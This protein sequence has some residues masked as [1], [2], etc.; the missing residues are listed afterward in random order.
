MGKTVRCGVIGAGAIGLIHLEGFK[1]H[2]DVELVGVAEVN[3]QRRQEAAEKFKLPKAVE[4]YTELLKDPSIDV[5]SIGL[6]NYLH[7]DVAVAAIKAGKHVMLDKPMATSAAEGQKIIDAWKEKKVVFMIGQNFRFNRETQMVKEYVKNGELGDIY[8]ARAHW[9]RRSGIPRI[10]SWFTQKKY[11]GGGCCYDIGVHFLDA[12]LHLMGTFVAE[13]VTGIVQ[14]KFG[15]RGLGDGT[16]G[17]GEIDASKPFDVEDLAVA[18]IKLKGGKS[19][20]L[21]ISWAIQADGGKDN[22]IDLY[23]TEG[24]ANLFPA[25]IYKVKGTNY[26]TITPDFK[27][28]PISEDRMVHFIDCVQGK[29]DPIVKPEESLKVQKILD[30]IYESSKTGRE[31]RLS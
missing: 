28:L 20:L 13:C 29:C 27:T 1:K 21:E 7:S 26:E 10:G 12:T 24:G 30:G 18:M 3:A 5:V 22:G 17:K 23:G 4:D 2:P 31:V 15:P 16:W 25:K 6:P 19:V 14:A 8:H 9:L 11:A